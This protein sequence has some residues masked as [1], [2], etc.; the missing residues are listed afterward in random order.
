MS[1]INTLKWK[2]RPLAMHLEIN[3][4]TNKRNIKKIKYKKSYVFN[5]RPKCVSL[6]EELTLCGEVFRI[7]KFRL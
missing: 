4:Y 2:M 6:Q 3:L 5:L 7:V 1:R